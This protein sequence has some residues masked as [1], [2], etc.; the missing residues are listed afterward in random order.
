MKLVLVAVVVISA[1]APSVQAQIRDPNHAQPMCAT[2][3]CGEVAEHAARQAYDTCRNGAGSPDLCTQ[4]A[5]DAWLATGAI[6]PYA[7]P[8]TATGVPKDYLGRCR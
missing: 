3:A 4:K 8:C 7:H 5:L 6:P 2:K 1:A